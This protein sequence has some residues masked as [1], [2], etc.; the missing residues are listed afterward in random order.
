MILV[1]GATGFLGI[2]L[3]QELLARGKE[4]LGFDLDEF[5]ALARHILS[6][7]EC[8]VL[9]FIQG[10][11]RNR[12]VVDD[13]FKKHNIEA[14]IHAG[15]LTILGP[16]GRAQA[17]VLFDTNVLGTLNLLNVAQERQIFRFVYVSSSG[18]YGNY[19]HEVVPVHETTPY[20]PSDLYVTT[21]ICSELLCQQF[22]DEDCFQVVVARIGSP[23]GPWGRPT[24]SQD[25]VPILN[26]MVRMAFKGQEVRIFG[27]DALRDWTHIRDIAAGISLITLADTTE[28]HYNVYN[29]TTGDNVSIGAIV[30]CIQR[31]LPE[32]RHRYVGSEAEANVIARHTNMRGPLDISRLQRDCGF[33]ARF[34]IGKG[35]MDLVEWYRQE[36]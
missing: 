20:A 33:K 10:D 7:T 8:G 2:N 3:V 30:R 18:V 17:R 1:T 13:V 24:N 11:F 5:P 19:G 12:K 27:C 14:V 36:L 4:V 15:A 25:D 29:I 21:K 22:H 16:E 9:K 6:N 35:L 23:Y 28:L 31:F 34:D 26:E 32:F